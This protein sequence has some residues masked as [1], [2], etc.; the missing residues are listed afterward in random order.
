MA[1]IAKALGF[2]LFFAIA[3]YGL[4]QFLEAQTAR[5]ALADAEAYCAERGG[6]DQIAAEGGVVDTASCGN[7]DIFTPGAGS[8]TPPS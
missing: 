5:G 4:S 6:I 7:G 3:A 1:R 2:L 8:A